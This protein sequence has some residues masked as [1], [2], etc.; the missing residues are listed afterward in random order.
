MTASPEGPLTRVIP[1]EAI[2]LTCNGCRSPVA[3]CRLT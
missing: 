3:G 2:E 1:L